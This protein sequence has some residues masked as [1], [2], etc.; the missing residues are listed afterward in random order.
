VG[1]AKIYDFIEYTLGKVMKNAVLG[2][3]ILSLVTGC[4]KHGLSELATRLNQPVRI[5]ID[6]AQDHDWAG[7][8]SDYTIGTEPSGVVF[9]PRTLPAPFQGRGLYSAGTNHSDDLFLY[10]KKHLDG[11]AA[12]QVYFLSFELMFLTDAP[13][14]CIGVGGSPGESVTVKAGATAV[15]PITILQ[16]D[17]FV[18]NIDKGSQTNPG[19]DA[20]VL[21]NLANTNKDC[22]HRQCETKTIRSEHPQKVLTDTSGAL[23]IMFGIDSGFEAGSSLYYLT[24]DVL[25]APETK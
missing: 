18:I 16:G 14:H 4:E 17:E 1:L 5:A 8:Q 13:A 19:P 11:F 2:I 15:E 3:I 9:E 20:L 12:N 25:A 10:I 7:G 21:G 6:F 24:A 22:S 23:W